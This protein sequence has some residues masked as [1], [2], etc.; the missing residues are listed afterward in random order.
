[1]FPGFDPS[2][3]TWHC[4]VCREERPDAQI[5][6]YK[7]QVTIAG[8]A[9]IDFNLKYCND[10]PECIA[11]RDEAA[12]RKFGSIPEHKDATEE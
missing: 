3:L 4:D 6:V 12:Q 1:M 5:S 11:G 2:K 7:T 10:K 8:G 9:T